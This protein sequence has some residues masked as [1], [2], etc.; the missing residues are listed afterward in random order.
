MSTVIE[1]PADERRKPKRDYPIIDCDVHPMMNSPRGLAPY[2]SA[3]WR[4]RLNIG[5]YDQPTRRVPRGWFFPGQVDGNR[6]DAFPEGGGNA[7]SDQALMVRQVFDE[8]RIGYAALMPNQ[9]LFLG[10]LP[11][12]DLAATVVSA[13]N[14]WLV[15][16]WLSYDERFLGTISVAPQDPQR[17]AAEIRRLA[18][19]PRMVQIF[20]ATPNTHRLGNP[21]FDPIWD[22]AQE[23]DLPVVWH[24][25]G[26]TPGGGIG[27]APT[28]YIE[29]F[30]ALTYTAQAQFGSVITEGV[31]EKF[32]KA[33]FAL[34]EGGILWVL[35]TIWRIRRAWLANRDECPW[36][37]RAPEEYLM[38]HIRISTQ[39]MEESAGKSSDVYDVLKVLDGDRWLIYASDYPHW[40]FDNPDVALR[41]FPDDSRRKIMYENPKA[42]Y[43]R[44]DV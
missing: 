22:A 18:D 23:V 7:G 25:G 33:R 11:N 44:L 32:P 28:S 21:F 41:G 1:T 24:P 8:A 36:M 34:I 13:F 37:K 6:L 26:G 4:E 20:V 14:D 3:A 29:G 10:G 16:D 43:T 40:D 42:F 31:F 2:L 39:P 27:G 17:A 19:N 30:A 12:A 35:S 38:D 9:T 15:N 5:E